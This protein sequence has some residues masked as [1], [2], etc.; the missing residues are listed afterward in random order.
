L[1]SLDPDADPPGTGEVAADVGFG[2]GAICEEAV[3]LEPAADDLE[4]LHPAR[5]AAPPTIATMVAAP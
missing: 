3:G 1:T 4:L 5:Q 2:V